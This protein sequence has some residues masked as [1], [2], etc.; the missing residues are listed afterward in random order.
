MCVGTT[1]DESLA[2]EFS[3]VPGMEVT[4]L[5]LSVSSLCLD[6]DD[7]LGKLQLHMYMCILNKPNG[8]V[9]SIPFSAYIC[10]ST[11]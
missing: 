3:D 7:Y 5:D 9:L 2:R 1:I 8:S 6:H 4:F 10:W 11:F